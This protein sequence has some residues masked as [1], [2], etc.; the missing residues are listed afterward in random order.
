M[1]EGGKPSA[2][3]RA[4]PVTHN[5]KGNPSSDSSPVHSAPEIVRVDGENTGG[6]SAV[7]TTTLD[8]IEEGKGGW[9]AYLKTRNFY[10]V[11]VLG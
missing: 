10:I 5:T 3:E 6:E 4:T 1:E 7:G 9:F 8:A 2:I 11:L